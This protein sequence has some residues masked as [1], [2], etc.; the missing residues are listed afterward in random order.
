MNKILNFKTNISNN[1]HIS[2]KSDTKLGGNY[3]AIDFS[4]N[5]LATNQPVEK[6]DI[7]KNATENS[8]VIID[9]K[10]IV[11]ESQL[12]L[13]P[14]PIENNPKK[15]TINKLASKFNMVC[16][17]III[18]V[19]LANDGSTWT[20]HIRLGNPSVDESLDKTGNYIISIVETYANMSL[21]DGEL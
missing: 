14:I 18:S 2:I 21:P 13:P 20:P 12:R 7:R 17:D 11:N 6:D 4:I 9:D 1:P 15:E 3:T 8:A 10:D 16:D 5:W 19:K